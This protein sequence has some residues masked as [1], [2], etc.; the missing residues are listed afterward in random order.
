MAMKLK[1]LDYTDVTIFEKSRRVGGKS[2]DVK[3][4]GASYPI[5]TVFFEPSYF[6]NVV[7]LAREY[8][9]GEY[10]RLPSVGIWLENKGG[11]NITLNHYYGL[12]LSKFTNSQ[13]PTVNVV[14]MVTKI[15]NYIR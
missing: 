15:I 9:V 1:K 12:E 14:F 10:L 4:R 11:A 5:G 2:N 7:P 6:D 3:F 13:D 8:G